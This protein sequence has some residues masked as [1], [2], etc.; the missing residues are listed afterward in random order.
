MQQASGAGLILAN[1]P[2]DEEDLLTERYSFSSTTVVAKSAEDIKA[3]I[4][5][6]KKPRAAAMEIII[7]QCQL[8]QYRFCQSNIFLC[9]RYSID[10]V[11]HFEVTFLSF[12]WMNIRYQKEDQISLIVA[13]RATG[14]LQ[15]PKKGNNRNLS[16]HSEILYNC[17]DHFVH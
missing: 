17:R 12:L 15:D 1:G 7:C 6:T 11:G 9:M 8:H 14:S 3:Y 10:S 5:N 2:A 4:N 13:V 16:I